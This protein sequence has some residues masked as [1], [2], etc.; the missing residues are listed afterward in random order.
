MDLFNLSLLAALGLAVIAAIVW[1]TVRYTARRR[2]DRLRAQGYRLIR[3]L[4]AY[5]AWVDYQRDDPLLERSTDELTS[6]EPLAKALAIKDAAFPA[7]SQHMLR[8][9]Q[10][11]SLLIEYLWQHNL[12]RLSQATGWVPAYQD[13]QYQQIRG[14]QE[15]LIEEMIALCHELMG[16]IGKTWQ[17]TGSDFNF[18]SSLTMST[19]TP[20]SGA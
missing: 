12:L 6:P 20:G 18:S 9:L 10:A 14:A 2:Q 8:L 1:R 11:H 19:Q 3:W 4:N 16:D 7:L 5:S 13:P 17:V 15:D